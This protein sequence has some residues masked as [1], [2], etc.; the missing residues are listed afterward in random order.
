MTGESKT[1]N[2]RSYFFLLALF[3]LNRAGQILYVTLFVLAVPA[4]TVWT[5]FLPRFRFHEQ[6]ERLFRPRGTA[7]SRGS[8]AP[9]P[10][11]NINAARPSTPRRRCS[12]AAFGTRCGPRPAQDGAD[13]SVAAR[14]PSCC[15]SRKTREKRRRH[16]S[17]PR[18]W[19]R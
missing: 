5:V 18:R 19:T 8:S 17:V 3:G 13:P 10:R 9:W 14:R 1:T 12:A 11:A 7:T 6:D 16:R 4:L 15:S 2:Q